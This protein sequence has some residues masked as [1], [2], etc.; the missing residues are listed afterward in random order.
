M[1]IL[2][3][4]VLA[5]SLVPPAALAADPPRALAAADRE[6]A[7]GR[8]VRVTLA[9]REIETSFD[10]GR[11]AANFGG[12][13]LDSLII[14]SMDNKRQVLSNSAWQR[15]EAAALPLREALQGF[16]VDALALA[17]TRSALAQ[18][19]WFSPREVTAS[20]DGSPAAL[21][22]FIA[23]SPADHLAFVSY[24]YDLSPDFTQIRV[25]ADLS[26]A[27]KP[28]R[29]R[30]IA[31]FYEQHLAS[32]VQLSERS[33]EHRDNVARWSANDGALAR[34]ALARAF[35]QLEQLIPYALG[36][37]H[38]DVNALADKKREKVFAAGLYGP[39]VRR[40]QQRPDDVLIWADG[41]VYVQSLP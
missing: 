21:R 37:S 31:P 19:T 11:V 29:N 12:G 13:L 23:S 1:R 27:R 9:Q 35:A 22:A 5:C 30:E 25:Y 40:G 26:L 7:G 41:L 28:G 32:I 36:L 2:A 15:A 34:T 4:I 39:L 20:N 17:T 33:Y 38:A 10:V 14:A 24:R 18:A 16:D 6:A 8:D 3:A